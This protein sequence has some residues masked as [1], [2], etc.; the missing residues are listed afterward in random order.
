MSIKDAAFHAN[1]RA[2]IHQYTAIES[3]VLIMVIYGDPPQNVPLSSRRNESLPSGINAFFLEVV[4]KPQIAS[5]NKAQLDEK[6]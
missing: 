1:N 2:V 6:A 5:D 3:I 4:S